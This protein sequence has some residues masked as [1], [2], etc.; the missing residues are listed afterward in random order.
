MSPF[1]LHGGGAL[2][3]INRGVEGRWE[4]PSGVGLGGPRDWGGAR[5]GA[6][7]PRGGIRACGAYS[8]AAG[9]YCH[10]REHEGP[11]PRAPHGESDPRA[12]L[13]PRLVILHLIPA[14]HRGAHKGTE[15]A[16][17]AWG[18][19]EPPWDHPSDLLLVTNSSPSAPGL[20]ARTWGFEELLGRSCLGA[21]GG[22]LW[23]F[24][25]GM[26]NR[27]LFSARL[28]PSLHCPLEA[29]PLVSLPPP[30]PEFPF[31]P[32]P[33]AR[34]GNEAARWVGVASAGAVSWGSPSPVAPITCGSRS[35]LVALG[36]PG[37]LWIK[38]LNHIYPWSAGV[39]GNPSSHCPDPSRIPRSDCDLSL[40][41]YLC[42]GGLWGVALGAGFRGE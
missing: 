32:H 15:G 5:A 14:C 11:N 39:L 16:L 26:Q 13:T 28:S 36:I 6:A 24:G 34:C 25:G 30:C 31:Q 18:T 7:Q 19:P 38:G 33:W 27:D 8:V 40:F 12:P 20:L 4:W 1:A 21:I 22:L 10:S 17:Q 41:S 9:A 3:G 37:L 29:E 35:T 23:G 2:G 42:D